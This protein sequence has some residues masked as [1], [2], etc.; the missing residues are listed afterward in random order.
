M[1]IPANFSGKMLVFF[2]TTLNGRITSESLLRIGI[3][4]FENEAAREE[5]REEFIAPRQFDYVFDG[6]RAIIEDSV[7]IP[8]NRCGIYNIWTTDNLPA[9]DVRAHISLGLL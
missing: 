3:S 5:Y 4:F 6:A 1:D 8:S 9:G 7:L 2:Y